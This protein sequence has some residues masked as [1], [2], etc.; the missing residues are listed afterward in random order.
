[1]GVCVYFFRCRRQCAL[2]YSFD[3]FLDIVYVPTSLIARVR[4][5]RCPKTKIRRVVPIAAVVDGA[6]S[7][8]GI[9]AYLVMLVAI[10]LQAIGEQR[11]HS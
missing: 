5:G 7:W 6:A 4:V 1:M 2:F 9:V 8:Q 10:G 3:I 11:V